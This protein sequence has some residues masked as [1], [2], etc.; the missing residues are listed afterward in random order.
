M[1]SGPKTVNG[2]LLVKSTRDFVYISQEVIFL[3][4]VVALP[5]GLRYSPASSL[6]NKIRFLTAG[7]TGKMLC[8]GH[9]DKRESVCLSEAFAWDQ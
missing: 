1:A 6:L 8:K 3:V 2:L 9:Y 4:P 7:S 5:F